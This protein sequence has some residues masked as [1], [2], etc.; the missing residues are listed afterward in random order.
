MLNSEVW[1]NILRTSAIP[2]ALYRASTNGFAMEFANKA[3]QDIFGIKDTGIKTSSEIFSFSPKAENEVYSSLFEK[4]LTKVF[5]TG[6]T[7]RLLNLE[8][9]I[10]YPGKASPDW[11]TLDLENTAVIEEGAPVYV[12]QT[13]I[14]HQISAQRFLPIRSGS[15][16][17]TRA[18]LIE[19]ILRN[20]D[21][22]IN[23]SE[24]LIWSV[25]TECKVITANKAFFNVLKHTTSR[26]LHEGDSV[27]DNAFS[28]DVNARWKSYY[29]RALGGETFTIKEEFFN[30][31]KDRTDYSVVSFSPMRNEQG[32]IFGAACYSKDVTND[33]LALNELEKARNQT[34]KIMESSLDVICTID[35]DGCFV[36]ISAA[37]Q[38]IWG[39]SP[40]ELRGRRYLELVCEEDQALTIQAARDIMG[41]ANLTNFENRYVRKDGTL[42]PMVWSARWDDTDGIMYCIAKD[43]TER[44][45]A[46]NN[47]IASEKR[48][49][50]LVENGADAIIILDAAGKQS[51]VSPS[52]KAVLGYNEE[53]TMG[54]ILNDLIHPADHNIVTANIAESFKRP[55]ETLEGQTARVKHKDG[56]WRWLEA[57]LTNMLHDPLINGI[58]DNFRDVTVRHEAEL[59]KNL[60]INNTD[61]SFVL[62]NADLEI[63]SF[64]DQFYRLYKRY[65]NKEVQKGGAI[66]E[67]AQ[68]KSRPSLRETYRKVL[69]GAFE[70]AEINVKDPLTHEALVYAIKYKPAKNLEG[71]IIG[72]F[73]TALD[74]TDRQMALERMTESEERYKL[75]FKSSPLPKFVYELA[76]LKILEVN[77]QAMAVYGYTQEE[78]CD[79][80]LLHIIPE[81][82]QNR[83]VELH[84][85][86]QLNAGAVDFGIFALHK[87]NSALTLAEVSGFKIDY[88]GRECMMAYFNDVTVREKALRRL[89]DNEARLLAAQKIAK[90]GYWQSFPDREGLYWSDE[91]YNIWGRDKESFKLTFESHFDT[92]HPEDRDE[93]L[94]SR[95]RAF[96]EGVQHNVEHRIMLPDGTI[97]W[98]HALG[99]LIR[100]DG[101]EVIIFEGTVQDITSDKLALEQLLISEARHRGI[102]ESQT[103]YMIRT[104]L[105]GNYLFCNHKFLQ[106]FGWLYEGKDISDQNAMSSIMP[107]HHERVARIVAKCI[108][109]VNQVFQVLIDKPRKGGKGVVSTLW[110]FIC[111]TDSKG[112]ASE[113]QCI[114]IDMS[115]WKRAQDALEISNARYEYVTRA[116]SDAIWDWDL[117]TG[118]V[119]HGV[120][121][122]TL[123]GHVAGENVKR[124]TYWENHAHQDDLSSIKKVIQKAGLGTID[125]WTQEYRV[126]DSSGDYVFVREKGIVIRDSHG[127]PINLIGAVQDISE[128][129]IADLQKSFLAE[130]SRLFN[131]TEEHLNEILNQI[132]H[133]VVSVAECSIAEIWLVNADRT[134]LLRAAQQVRD[135]KLGGFHERADKPRIVKGEGLPG[136]VWQT[137]SSQEWTGLAEDK[138]FVRNKLAQKLGLETGLGLPLIYNGE[139]LGVLLIVE[140][141][142]KSSL[143]KHVSFQEAFCSHLSAEIKRKQLDRD[144]RQIFSFAPDIISVAGFDG[145]LKKINPAACALL[146]YTEEELLSRPVVDFIH[147]D[148]QESTVQIIEGMTGSANTF[149]F[150]NRYVSK[151]GKT[152]WLGWTSTPSPADGLVFAVAKDITEKKNLE[153][154]LEKSYKLAELGTWEVDMLNYSINWSSTTKE[155]HEVDPGFEPDLHTAITFYEEGNGR[156]SI[157]KAVKKGFRDGSGWDME[158]KILT[159]KGNVRWVRAIGEAELINGKLIRLYGTIQNITNRKVAELALIDL[160]NEKNTILESIRD[161][162]FAVDDSWK[163]T[164][165]NK[166][167]EKM[168]GKARKQAVGKNLWRVF[169]RMTD[170][171]SYQK[172]Q[173]AVDT[174]QVVHFEDYYPVMDKWYEI[175]AYP[176]SVGLSVFFKDVTERKISDIMIKDLNGV[177]H[178]KV[179]ELA[180]SNREL[181]EFA[182]VASH[183]LQEPLR[184]ISSFLTQLQRKY[185]DQLDAKA[186]QYINFAV[187]GAHRMRQIILDLLDFSRVGRAEEIPE[188]ISMNE[189]VS[190]ILGLYRKKIDESK[191]LVVMSDMPFIHVQKTSI[192]QL[193]QNLISNALKYHAADDTPLVEIGYSELPEN[194]EFWVKDNGIGISPEYFDKIFIIF[195]R[196]HTK[197]Q[198]SGTGI[199]LAICRKIVENFGGK[200]WIES[201]VGTGSTFF[202]TVP[203]VL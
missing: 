163:V 12:C 85:Q 20:Q 153:E 172:Y 141:K 171:S 36:S 97:K 23:S 96:K 99:N 179:T 84:K 29:D 100:N 189:V 68:F 35:V 144:L 201:V 77:D 112:N 111:L 52:I 49:R 27:Q 117:T 48:Y 182:Y 4:S 10:Q 195:Q 45:N 11:V 145:Y 92:I 180:V 115:E 173:E 118:L 64:N 44:R 151:S 65:F 1:L 40:E 161:G 159:G 200:L 13:I 134:L 87:K 191:A 74:I 38:K 30:P 130:A 108:A 132:L 123:F 37:A 88:K 104:D 150:E 183:D 192:R 199:G 175:S 25:D 39:Y 119:Y 5:K 51:Y 181:E 93:F 6:K 66:L 143:L 158:V 58:V 14:R 22:L 174:M 101:G 170:S 124:Y 133:H 26:D 160:F 60:L 155:I 72:V 41:G 46:E 165:W 129:K 67:Y 186:H 95:E 91:V 203:K 31:E 83:F 184:M 94:K 121:F 188:L 9:T 54:L 178:K 193:M 185:D 135:V 113:I 109:D 80:T 120:G 142:R 114:G 164:Y 103:N 86:K 42:V 169:A 71:S 2:L 90:V 7:D 17:R 79:K 19:I 110:D 126:R 70:S 56:S 152:I 202:F 47:L 69:N 28:D 138:R 81:Y 73:V 16:P 194:W 75:L 15:E 107:Y 89:E 78:F 190:D 137:L 116:T 157:R 198:Y 76:T 177:L 8:F 196:L 128:E 32:E 82:D 62:I 127:T 167:A 24:D 168:L 149:Y 98:V 33:T 125:Q 131:N 34:H 187:D 21:A 59:E 50:T 162:F 57:T 61:E 53:E 197:D 43:A 136:M 18:E 148:D 139:F 147:P 146:E 102:I 122:Q 106:D 154:L 166:E 105:V 3:Y 156:E 140:T 176:S 63:V 55:G